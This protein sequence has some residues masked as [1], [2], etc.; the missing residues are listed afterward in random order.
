MHLLGLR[1]APLLLS[2]LS[3]ATAFDSKYDLSRAFSTEDRVGIPID[4]CT[5]A[6]TL[7][8]S[9]LLW[10]SQERWARHADHQREMAW[11]HFFAVEHNSP[12]AFDACKQ[13]E[14]MWLA[15][16]AESALR[17]ADQG[18]PQPPAGSLHKS[19]PNAADEINFGAHVV[20]SACNF[21]ICLG[22]SD[23]S[24]KSQLAGQLGRLIDDGTIVVEFLSADWVGIALFFMLGE[25]GTRNVREEY[26]KNIS[27]PFVFPTSVAASHSNIGAMCE[28]LETVIQL[29]LPELHVVLSTT[30]HALLAA[31]DCWV[32]QAF[33]A[34]LPWSQIRLYFTSCFCGGLEWQI[35]FIADVLRWS[36]RT[37]V[38]GNAP[39]TFTL[40][41]PTTFEGF[42]AD[43]LW[44]QQ[45]CSKRVARMCVHLLR[46]I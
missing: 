2:R 6:R 11:L 5:D 15:A 9:R 23:Q 13:L 33:L 38:R 21:A 46:K 18:T 12:L 10:H 40:L 14:D 22:L 24:Q 44:I 4:C 28:V 26:R 17:Q 25:S 35:G 34:V 3:C 37:L 30:A 32:R 20:A 16:A 7:L 42:E 19:K 8:T 31:V 41:D 36:R 27:E 39:V 43:F 45:L 1:V 29:E